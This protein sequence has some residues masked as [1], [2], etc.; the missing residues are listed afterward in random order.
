VK[1]WSGGTT[2]WD[3]VGTFTEK[4]V[5]DLKTISANVQVGY[6]LGA[7]SSGNAYVGL[8]Y[9][10]AGAGVPVI[11]KLHLADGAIDADWGG[12]RPPFTS[13]ANSLADA[14]VVEDPTVPGGGYVYW[15]GRQQVG[16]PAQNKRL[17]NRYR[18]DN[19][20]WL[21]SFG[22]A[23]TGTYA[24]PTDATYTV[25]D[26]DN[27]ASPHYF[28]ADDKG[29]LY[30][31][32]GNLTKMTKVVASQ[33]FLVAAGAK[34]SA[35]AAVKSSASALEGVTYF[36]SDDGK[37]YAYTIAD[38]NPVAG[39]PVDIAAATA[40]GVKIQ[41][42]P[43]VYITTGGKQIYFTTDRG[44]IGRVNA[45]GTDLTVIN[46]PIPGA[47]NT[48]TPAVT[49]D[50]TIYVGG[51][52]ALGAGVTKLDSGLNVLAYQM[53]G[54][55]ATTVSSV[56]VAGNKVYVGT[57]GGLNGDIVVLNADDLTPL[58]SGLAG[59]EG[60]TA[61]PYVSGPDMYVGTLAGNFYKIN[62]SNGNPDASFGAGNVPSTPG[63]AAIGEPLPGS[64][65]RPMNGP[66]LAGSNNGKVWW[67]EPADGSFRVFY[68]TGEAS[69]S[70][71]GVV[72]TFNSLGFGTSAGTF[73]TVRP[74]GG[75][76][77]AFRGHGAFSGAPAY[78]ATTGRFVI[79]SDDGDV[80]TFHLPF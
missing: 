4:W 69:A 54:T 67:I 59:G 17:V 19:G 71:A 47:N 73:Y 68:D 55:A 52:T 1:H 37:L 34:N 76:I 15:G 70:I 78:D 6:G 24:P 56:A 44:D 57:V 16:S 51:N 79:G 5:T 20:A 8:A 11:A 2:A 9:N 26:V 63:R 46:T 49:A 3:A 21:D 7:D 74:D 40:P 32:S 23:A 29:N 35:G 65:F 10:A 75:L 45:D 61:P 13:I 42:R 80:Y 38:G 22:P 41:S 12:K 30:F 33:P 31:N 36:G 27:A 72:P 48:G 39:F 18:L 43:S 77:G 14:E 62:S 66:F 53:L 28:G 58:T 64:A 60:V 50:G 25:L